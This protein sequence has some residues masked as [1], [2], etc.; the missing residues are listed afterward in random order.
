MLHKQPVIGKYILDTLS[1]GMYNNPLMLIREYVQNSV[2]AIDEST[3]NGDIPLAKARIEI[4]I[5]G[6]KKSLT[7]IDNGA[8]V[9]ASR[10][11]NVLHDIG[12]SFKR[13]SH[14]RGFRGIGRLGGL[15]YCETL[16]F[17]TKAK[18][19][20]VYSIS[21]WDC[22]RLRQ[23]I[24]RDNK[25]SSLIQIINDVVH[26]KK[27]KYTRNAEDHFFIV[28]MIN[29]KNSRDVLLNVPDVKAYISEVCPVPFNKHDFSY[30][31][32]IEKE[33]KS[34]VP[35]YQTYKISVNKEIIFKPYSNIVFLGD[36]KKDKIDKIELLELN[37]NSKP[38]A[39]GWIANL[40]LLGSIKSSSLVDGIKVRAGNI[41]IGDKHLLADFYRERRFNNYLIGELH[42]TNPSLIP[43]SRRDDFEDNK[44]KEEF[45]NCFIKEIG[46]PFSKAIRGSSVRRSQE[47]GLKKMESLNDT[48]LTILKNGY[49]SSIQQKDIISRLEIA[50]KNNKGI[51]LEKVNNWIKDLSN[52]RHFLDSN[53][54]KKGISPQKK[55]LLKKIFDIIYMHSS[56]KK[57][58][59]RIINNIVKK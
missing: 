23:L 21:E 59:E 56:N 3:K 9:K 26:F 8:G 38:L 14:N 48:I 34:R 19:E 15:G 10:A 40:K 41:L 52:T 44:Y 37:N 7:I 12:K 27:N 39:F 46:I 50:K 17:T 35:K 16:K 55:V 25:L 22:N 24:N 53:N 42:I 32:K 28:E 54:Y 49:L 13:I 29:L 6:R 45:Y 1:I 33:L 43:N 20:D 18:G 31:R 57:E 47:N 11:Y 5:D 58:A 30:A 51:N 2:D 36:K 4:K